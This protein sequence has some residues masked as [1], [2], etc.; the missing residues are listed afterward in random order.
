MSYK[1]AFKF[2]IPL[3]KITKLSSYIFFGVGRGHMIFKLSVVAFKFSQELR[4]WALV[5]LQISCYLMG[6]YNLC[7]VKIMTYPEI[8]SIFTSD[9]DVSLI[10]K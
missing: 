4:N 8:W 1:N 7:N 3:I 9:E 5:G 6:I 10:F 2:I